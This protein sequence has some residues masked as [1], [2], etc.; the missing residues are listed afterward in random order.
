MELDLSRGFKTILWS[1]QYFLLLHFKT[2]S[3]F[4]SILRHFTF[5][6]PPSCICSK[7]APSPAPIISS[8]RVTILVPLSQEVKLSPS[9]LIFIL[10]HSPIFS[11]LSFLGSGFIS[12]FLP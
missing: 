7:T 9:T 3:S 6:P 5:I 2:Y 10:F 4:N 12:Q 8:L 1:K 11:A